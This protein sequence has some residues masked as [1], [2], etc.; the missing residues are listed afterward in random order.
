[1]TR[2]PPPLPL[3]NFSFKRDIIRQRDVTLIDQIFNAAGF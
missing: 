3:L 2:P 1:M